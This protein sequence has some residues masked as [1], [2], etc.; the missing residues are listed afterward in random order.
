MAMQLVECP[1]NGGSPTWANSTKPDP[2][3]VRGKWRCTKCGSTGHKEAK[4]V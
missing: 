2:K 4:E 3:A 1:D